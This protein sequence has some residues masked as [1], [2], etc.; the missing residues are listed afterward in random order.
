VGW[1]VAVGSDV[2]AVEVSVTEAESE[3]SGL[4]AGSPPEHA[5]TATDAAKNAAARFP[6]PR[7]SLWCATLEE[8]AALQNGQ[9]DS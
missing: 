9:C 7:P 1:A 2:L 5:A 6:R 4:L 3:P 8:S